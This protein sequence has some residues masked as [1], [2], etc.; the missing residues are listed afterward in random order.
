MPRQLSFIY[1]DSKI[2][3]LSLK[4]NLMLF[5]SGRPQ[6]TCSHGKANEASTS[7]GCSKRTM[8]ET[9]LND[10]YGLFLSILEFM[11]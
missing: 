6:V 3:P 1:V 4:D 10:G 5:P 8:L 11:D 7:L 2:E 9:L